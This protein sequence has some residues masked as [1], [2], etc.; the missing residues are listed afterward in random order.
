MG[1]PPAFELKEMVCP[2]RGIH[3]PFHPPAPSF[4]RSCV[5]SFV[6]QATRRLFRAGSERCAS[7][8]PGTKEGRQE[9]LRDALTPLFCSGAPVGNPFNP[10]LGA[11]HL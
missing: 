4:V 9:G 10:S 2:P 7:R 5:H 1:D 11:S 6:Q 3:L 8:P